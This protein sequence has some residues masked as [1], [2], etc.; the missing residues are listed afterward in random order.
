M[1]KTQIKCLA[2]AVAMLS[3]TPAWAQDQSTASDVSSAQNHDM[4]NMDHGS[5]PI[6]EGAAT[7]GLRD[8]HVYSDGYTLNSGP[9]VHP[10][11]Q[12]LHLADE[13]NLGALQ[14]NRLERIHTNDN[15]STAYDVQAW[16]G[17]DYDRLVIKAEGDAA[18]GKLQ[19]NRTELLWGH[20]VASFW[21][22]QLGVRHDRDIGPDRGWL[23][24]GAQGLAPYWF[25]IDA[26]AYAGDNGNTALRLSAEYELLLTQKLILQPRAEMNLYGKSDTARDIGSG[27]S[28]GLA[29]LRLRYEI[30]RQFAPYAGI[31]WSGKFG[32]TAN[33]ADATGAKSSETR[34]V[35]GVRFW[36]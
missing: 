29:G 2:V 33:M 18:Q 28:D 31:E 34:W 3:L 25:E 12:H 20:A 14:F 30:T 13:H 17:R 5:T 15:N 11:V 32:E 6:P 10:S 19:D 9:Y 36:F 21:D 16:F 35:A 4:S 22:M 26:T 24:L 1:M 23:A 7:T 8:P 27:L